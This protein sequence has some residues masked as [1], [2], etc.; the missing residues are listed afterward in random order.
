MVNIWRK[1]PGRGRLSDSDVSA[2]SF[3]LPNI[4][5]P[6]LPR[7]RAAAPRPLGP[8]ERAAARACRERGFRVIKGGR[9]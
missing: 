1:P 8:G 9:A 7:K 3:D 2:D 5:P 4:S 6:A